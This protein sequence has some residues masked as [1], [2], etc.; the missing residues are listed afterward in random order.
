MVGSKLAGGD[1]ESIT[2]RKNLF[3]NQKTEKG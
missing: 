3:S 2:D 1:S